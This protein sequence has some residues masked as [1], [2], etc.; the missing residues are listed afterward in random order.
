MSNRSNESTS[1]KKLQIKKI[2]VAVDGSPNSMRSADVAIKMSKDYGAELVVLHVV[3]YPIYHLYAP[4]AYGVAPVDELLDHEEKA[5]QHW[6]GPILDKARASG[7][8]ARLEVLKVKTSIVLAI[9][10]N[11]IAEKADLIVIGTRGLGG[12]AKLLLGSVSSGVVTHASCPVLVV[13]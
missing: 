3:Q 8:Y 10:D 9:T 13:R 1:T 4:R 6:A 2:I 5:A 11:A 7:V 12:F